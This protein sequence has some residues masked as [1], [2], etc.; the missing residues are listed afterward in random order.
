MFNG[1]GASNSVARPANRVE[2][3]VT[4]PEEAVLIDLCE[5][6]QVPRSEGV[7]TGRATS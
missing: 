4:L 6:D 1:P 2:F 7:D 5:F 3:M